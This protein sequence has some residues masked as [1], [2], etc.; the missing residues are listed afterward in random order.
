MSDPSSEESIFFAA[1]AKGTPAE[2]AAY[3]DEACGDNADL[4]REVERLLAAH[5][6]VGGFL[7]QPA[8]PPAGGTG[9]FAPSSA[10]APALTI[11]S[12]IAGKYKLR[13]RLGEGGMGVVYVADQTQPVQRRV[14]LKVVKA[15]LDSAA[16]LAR[17]EQERQ[18]LALMDHPHIAKVLDAGTTE[19]GQPFFVMEL[20]KGIPITKYC[21][22]GG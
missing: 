11:G 9:P 7:E 16:A 1:L 14:A 17:F 12:I 13:E 10:P 20:V 3:L 2:R 5:P 21:D 8:A 15:G 19:S 4:R 6:K 22:Q 18:A